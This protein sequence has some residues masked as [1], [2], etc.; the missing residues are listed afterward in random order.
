LFIKQF[1]EVCGRK[2]HLIFLI[3]VA[4]LCSATVCFAAHSTDVAR[5]SVL[6]QES[7]DFLTQHNIDLSQFYSAR[8]NDTVVLRNGTITTNPNN[9]DSAIMA[10]KHQAN[11][12]GFTDEQI[13]NYVRNMFEHPTVIANDLSNHETVRA[14]N[15][16]G[17]DGV[18]YEVKSQ[19]GY[20]LTTACGMIPSAYRGSADDTSAYMFW[21]LKDAI[22]IGIWYSNG[23]EGLGWRICWL[24][25]GSLDSVST[26]ET[27]LYAGRNVY[28]V[29]NIIDSNWAQIQIWDGIT[30]IDKLCDYSIYIGGLGITKTNNNMNR[31]ITLCREN[32]FTGGG[33]MTNAEFSLAYIYTTAGTYALTTSSNT[34]SNHVGAFG[35]DNTTLL[36]VNVDTTN[37]VQ[38]YQERVSIAF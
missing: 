21:T 25:N 1:K 14:D 7:I 26:P 24:V 23:V 12:Q 34:V 29:M 8:I 19:D 27:A 3:V 31:Q 30:F 38:W 28:F 2:K 37:T 5:D 6:S 16:P 33:Y 32:G 11:A 9:Y 13:A 10:L 15:R 18:G 35:T 17:D 4:I 20:Y 36:L 22:D